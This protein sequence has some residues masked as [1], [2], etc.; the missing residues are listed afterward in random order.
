[1]PSHVI[2]IPLCILAMLGNVGTVELDS[3]GLFGNRL[4]G[5]CKE[6]PLMSLV[7]SCAFWPCVFSWGNVEIDGEDLFGNRL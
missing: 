4:Y 5:L 3:E 2:S 7:F 6:D 1:M